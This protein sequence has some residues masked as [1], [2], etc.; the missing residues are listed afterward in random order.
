MQNNLITKEGY[1]KL[2][3]ELNEL[4][5]TKRAEISNKIKEAREQGDLSENAEYSAAKD[6]Q[7]LNESRIEQLEAI[8]KSVQVVDTVKSDI[9]DFGS[10][11]KLKDL[12][13]NK[14]YK[15]TIVGSNEANILEGRISNICPLGNALVGHKLNDTVS[16]ITTDGNEEKYKILEVV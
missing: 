10:T 5:T 12:N 13:D 6:E 11:V 2:V 16:Y 1:N 8:L 15:Y 4:K 9:V 3:E 7:T 14:E